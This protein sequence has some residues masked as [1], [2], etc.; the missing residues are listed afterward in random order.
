MCAG[1]VDCR[2]RQEGDQRD[3]EHRLVLRLAGRSLHPLRRATRV[4]DHP[5]RLRATATGVI[6]YI[7]RPHDG[8]V[9]VAQRS[10]NG[11]QRL[12]WSVIPREPF[13][14][15]LRAD[16]ADVPR[17]IR[18]QAYRHLGKVAVET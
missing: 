7:S 14:P 6:L 17:E 4:A 1:A 16:A 5:R 12:L 11:S 9:Y 2:G 15:E 18:R 8:L 10:R 13:G 3:Q